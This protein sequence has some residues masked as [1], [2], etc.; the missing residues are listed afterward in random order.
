MK[1]LNTKLVLSALGVVAMLASPAFAQ[2]SHRQPIGQNPY[3]GGYVVAPSDKQAGRRPFYNF[4]P[5]QQRD[6]YNYG[7]AAGQMPPYLDFGIEGQ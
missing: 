3:D 1:T 2:K 6:L 7:G 4:D 5:Q